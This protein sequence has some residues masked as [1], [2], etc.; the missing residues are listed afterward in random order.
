M[1]LQGV[2]REPRRQRVDPRIQPLPHPVD[3]LT[4]PVDSL[5]EPV[6]ARCSAAGT[7]PARPASAR[8]ARPAHSPRPSS[9]SAFPS[10]APRPGPVMIAPH[11]A[12]RIV[13]HKEG[14]AVGLSPE[15]VAS[16]LRVPG[17]TCT[18]RRARA[19]CRLR[20]TAP[21]ELPSRCRHG[22]YERSSSPRFSTSLRPR[23]VM[24]ACLVAGWRS[25]SLRSASFFTALVRL[26]RS[27]CIICC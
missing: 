5:A 16:L 20:Q 14:S 21:G 9:S 24:C 8:S 19:C 15:Q 4:E 3:P 7:S 23:L 6:D 2:L 12:V 10:D 18:C 27:P 22:G 17:R 11:H 1:P 13:V 25:K 26:L